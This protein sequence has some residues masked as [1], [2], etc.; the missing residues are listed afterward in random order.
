MKEQTRMAEGR[1]ISRRRMLK[2][3]SGATLGGLVPPLFASCSKKTEDVKQNGEDTAEQHQ[4]PPAATEEI[5]V[6]IIGCGRRS[7]QLVIGKGGQGKLPVGKGPSLFPP[8]SFRGPAVD[9][10]VEPEES[11]G[12]EV[13]E[14]DDAEKLAE[15]EKEAYRKGD[16]EV[17]LARFQEVLDSDP[18]NAKA[19][20][21]IRRISQKL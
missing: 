10:A 21:M 20:F 13:E 19:K 9:N 11:D 3:A 18:S 4:K 16:L 17:A 6:G 12:A 8:G 14:I 5:G 1:K 15:L 7:G 2:T